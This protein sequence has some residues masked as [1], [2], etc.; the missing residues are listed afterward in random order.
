MC[1]CLG[2]ED[3]RDTGAN[4]EILH[5]HIING[6]LVDFHRHSRQSLEQVFEGQLSFFQRHL[7]VFSVETSAVDIRADACL[8]WSSLATSPASSG[9]RS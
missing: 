2:S 8:L 5:L 4:E 1:V 7:E 9:A 6:E 3:L